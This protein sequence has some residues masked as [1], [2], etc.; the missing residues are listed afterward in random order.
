MKWLKLTLFSA[1]TLASF[2]GYAKS[3]GSD[4]VAEWRCDGADVHTA[5]LGPEV[6]RG[7]TLVL[8]CV[9]K[10]GAGK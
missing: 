7:D 2:T 1:L 6:R 3:A 10:R 4:F 9:S 8:S 5:A